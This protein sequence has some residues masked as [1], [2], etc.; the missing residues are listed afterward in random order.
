MR[1]GFESSCLAGQITGAGVQTRNLIKGLVSI[2]NFNKYVLCV[3]IRYDNSVFHFNINDIKQPNLQINQFNEPSSYRFMFSKVDFLNKIKPINKFN[4]VVD[5]RLL[6]PIFDLK[7]YKKHEKLIIDTSKGVDLF[8]YCQDQNMPVPELSVPTIVT[9]YELLEIEFPQCYGRG[10]DEKRKSGLVNFIKKGSYFITDSNYIREVFI[11][12]FKIQENRVNTIYPGI[13][14]PLLSDEEEK[15]ALLKFNIHKNQYFLYAGR[16]D[17]M[18]NLDNLIKAYDIFLKDRIA[19]PYKLIIA[20][21]QDKIYFP[22]VKSLVKSLGLEDKVMFL[23]NVARKQVYGLMRNAKLFIYP[24]SSEGCPTSVLEALSFGIPVVG[25]KIPVFQEITNG[26][27]ILV[28][29]HNP[30]E[31]VQAIKNIIK[32]SNL[33]RDLRQRALEQARNFTLDKAA[34]NTLEFYKKILSK[35]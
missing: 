15:E 9:V 17:W 35:K 11:K 4:E 27:A 13:D 19:H 6:R 24:S 3:Y 33:E 25:S 5:W 26:A 21:A 20:G 28:N 22:K 32:D 29:P 10:R 8:H 7:S 30:E 1:I 18:K 23:G 12:I 14:I 16:F 34:L 31:I 2:K